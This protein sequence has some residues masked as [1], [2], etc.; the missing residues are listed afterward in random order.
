MPNI[1]V[2]DDTYQK[3]KKGADAS[4]R[5]LGGQID[6]LISLD[7]GTPAIVTP[8]PKN[9]QVGELVRGEEAEYHPQK[10]AVEAEV[11]GLIKDIAA[12]KIKSM[13]KGDILA[14]IRKLE[15]D[16]DEELRYCQDVDESRKITEKYAK[17]IQ[18]LWDEYNSL[19]EA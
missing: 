14:D 7:K 6:F 2:S 17:L 3:L 4:F 13:G 15:A 8:L 18:P 5:T 9:L 1:K 11:I 19:K 10:K 16:R 12:D